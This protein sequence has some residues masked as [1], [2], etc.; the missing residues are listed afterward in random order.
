MADSDDE[1]KLTPAE[2]NAEA[3]E[4]QT[5]E[6]ETETQVD[7]AG[8]AAETTTDDDTTTSEE[9]KPR[10]EVRHERYIDKLSTEIREANSQSSRTVDDLF[11]APNPYQPLELKD[12]MEVD[13]AQLEEDR[14]KVGDGRYAEGLQ[15]G[16]NQSTSEVRKE[17]WAD[18]FDIDSERVTAR[19]SELNPDDESYN[20]RLEAY[21][22][23]QYIA[24]TGMEKDARG[25]VTIQ[26]DNIRFKDFVEAEM[27]NLDEVAT[28]RGATSRKNVTAQV[29]KTG[30]RPNNQ[31]RPS[32]G[33]H[34]F[35]PDDPVGSVNRMS[36]KQ[37]FELGGKEASDAYLAERGLAPK[38]T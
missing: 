13:P 28:A 10:G 12:G 6:G 11:T 24:F 4:D 8:Q 32:K 20:P 3:P 16:I 30:V 26:R 7:D 1:T 34:G 19:Y 9:R 31:G 15:T 23:G 37:Y 18:R 29:A 22:V 21:L 25:R 17:L 36:K 38:Q 35:N 33:D 14:K 5:G 2:S 27:K